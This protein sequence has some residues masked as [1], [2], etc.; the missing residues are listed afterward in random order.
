M[1]PLSFIYDKIQN[2]QDGYNIE[3]IENIKSK[4]S[5]TLEN[6]VYIKNNLENIKRGPRYDKN[7]KYISNIKRELHTYFD[8]LL[9]ILG[10]LDIYKQ[11]YIEFK[12]EY[13]PRLLFEGLYYIKGYRNVNLNKSNIKNHEQNILYH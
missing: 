5:C 6:L 4:I 8:E 3:E 2:L 13:L 1:P 9:N 10:L 7:L 12:K 11:S